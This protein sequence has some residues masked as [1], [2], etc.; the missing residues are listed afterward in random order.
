MRR[1]V[2][3][4]HLELR[5][6]RQSPP[7][8]LENNA[9]GL[10]TGRGNIG[11]SHVALGMWSRRAVRQGRCE[12]D[13]RSEACTNTRDEVDGPDRQKAWEALCR[14]KCVPRLRSV[15]QTGCGHWHNAVAI[16]RNGPRS[17]M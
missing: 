9:L 16:C 5:P 10:G 4:D 11:L 15:L 13:F 8:P 1:S 7:N 6:G 17:Q 3:A 2:V 14:P 12:A